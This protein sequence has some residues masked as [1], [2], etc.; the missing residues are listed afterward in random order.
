MA[1]HLEFTITY[2]DIQKATGL[3]MDNIYQYRRRGD[4][5]PTLEGLLLFVARHGKLDLRKR[6]INYC[7]ER[8]LTEKP[9]RKRRRKRQPA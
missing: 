6:V 1:P 2:D 4:L 5:E 8:V 7:L 3:S 9:G